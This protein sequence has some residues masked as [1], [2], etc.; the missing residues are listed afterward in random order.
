LDIVH[1]G[2]D[3]PRKSDSLKEKKEEGF[4]GSLTLTRGK[5]RM[6]SFRIEVGRRQRA[7]VHVTVDVQ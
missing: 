3:P 4:Y 1:L 7:I 6:N 5:S 2:V